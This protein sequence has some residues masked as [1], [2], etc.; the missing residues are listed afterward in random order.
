MSDSFTV[1]LPSELEVTMVRVFQAPRALVFEAH[2][3]CEHLKHWW[4]RGNPL[5]CT[6][7]FRPGG[8]YRF[9]EHAPDGHDYAFHGE[10]LEIRE[11]ELI[12]YT[13]EYEGA[14][15][16]VCVETLEF[17]EAEGSTTITGTT[18]FATP[19]DRDQMISAGMQDGARQSYQALAAYLAK[20]L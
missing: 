14:P 20:Q 6:I 18:R 4:G 17:T 19:E 1:N 12:R 8:V 5:E 16:H 9:V 13:F 2:A 11:P 7:D 3:A 15:G 10:Y